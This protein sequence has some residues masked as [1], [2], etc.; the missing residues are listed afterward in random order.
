[1]NTVKRPVQTR[2]PVCVLSFAV[3]QAKKVTPRTRPE[4][5]IKKENKTEQNPASRSLS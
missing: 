2:C 4:N 5:P 3:E 1:M